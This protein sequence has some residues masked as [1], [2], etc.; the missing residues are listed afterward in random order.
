MS[1]LKCITCTLYIDAYGIAFLD[2]KMGRNG[3]HDNATVIVPVIGGYEWDIMNG[4]Q[5]QACEKLCSE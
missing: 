5:T 4:S 3:F 1:I 2:M